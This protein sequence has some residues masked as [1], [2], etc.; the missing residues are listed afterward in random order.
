MAKRLNISISDD[1]Y[2]RLQAVKD[3]LN[4]SGVCQE[5][6]EKAVKNGGAF[7]TNRQW[8]TF[9]NLVGKLAQFIRTHGD[10]ADKQQMYSAVR[11][12]VYSFE[13]KTQ[14]E[15]SNDNDH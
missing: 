13:D 14:K 5:A 12:M 3:N 6:I 2:E 1:L 8:D 11:H 15:N 7:M 4:V 9:H 10:H